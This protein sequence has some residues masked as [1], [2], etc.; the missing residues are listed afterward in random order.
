M[1][2]CKLKHFFMFLMV[3][4]YCCYVGKNSLFVC[5][6][7]LSCFGAGFLHSKASLLA[8]SFLFCVFFADI[9]AARLLS[10]NK[11]FLMFFILQLVINF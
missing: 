9:S 7:H 8:P 2:D 11:R 3:K 5:L 1:D 6:P 4:Y 10:I